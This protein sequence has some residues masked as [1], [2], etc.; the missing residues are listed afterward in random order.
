VSSTKE[1]FQRLFANKMSESKMR[2]FLVS[3]PLDGSISVEYIATAAEVMRQNAIPLEVNEELREKLLDVV[4]TG[5]DK[6]GSFNISSTSALVCAGAGCYVAKHGNR[7]ITS[8]SGSADMLEVLGVRLDLDIKKSARLLEESG[9]TFMF[10]KNHHPA[11]K[12]IMPVRKSIDVK[13]IFNILGPLT[14]PANVKKSMLG[15]FDKELVPKIAQALKLNG[16][17]SALVVS[18]QEGMDEISL[19]GI[20]YA[21]RLKDNELEEFEIDPEEFG[22]KRAPL[23]AIVG[24]DAKQ[25]A[26]ITLDILNNRASD[27]QRDIVLLNTGASLMV[28][29]VARDIKE[30]IEMA[31]DTIESKKAVKKL[32][33]IVKV[34]NA[35]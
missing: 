12:F 8:K 24:G 16:F 23:E 25:N 7:S 6:I 14:N 33:E 22:L 20:T 1:M 32:E 3:I 2:E 17:K 34:S 28:D 4:G 15:V 10:A 11:M 31:R 29:G 19:S 27:A 18:S 30:G 35:L 13:T 26:K 9:F 5:G 21:C